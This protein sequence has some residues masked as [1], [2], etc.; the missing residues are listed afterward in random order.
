LSKKPTVSADFRRQRVFY[1]VIVVAMLIVIV[2][3]VDR[4]SRVLYGLEA[5]FIFLAFVQ[6]YLHFRGRRR[7]AFM[8]IMNGRIRIFRPTVTGVKEIV[9]DVNDVSKVNERN[10]GSVVSFRVHLASGEVIRISPERMLWMAYDRRVREESR[11]FLRGIFDGKYE[12]D[13]NWP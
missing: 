4:E 3:I 1:A 13:W 10:F 8:H 12:R 2:Y 6:I 5:L 7:D 11:E 9:F